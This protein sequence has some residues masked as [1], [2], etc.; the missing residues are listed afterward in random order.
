MFTFDKEITVED[1]I[2]R[3]GPS[4]GNFTVTV[5]GGPFPVNSVS[6]PTT[7]PDEVRCRFGEIT[8]RGVILDEEH[9]DHLPEFV[10]LFVRMCVRGRVSC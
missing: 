5:Y 10:G 2:P 3:G 1:V 6:N 7:M 8:V 9:V 4:S